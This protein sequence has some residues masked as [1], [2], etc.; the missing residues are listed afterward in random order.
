MITKSNKHE[1]KTRIPYTYSVGDKIMLEKPGKIPKMLK[2]RTGQH[3]VTKVNSNGTLAI[4]RGVIT[5]RIKIRG[6][7]PYRD[8]P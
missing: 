1:N 7:T 2:P 6:V 8:D 3:A 5:E 4:R